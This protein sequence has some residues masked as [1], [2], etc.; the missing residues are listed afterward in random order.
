MDFINVNDA[1]IFLLITFIHF[2]ISLTI[3]L[4]YLFYFSGIKFV[5][6]G[7]VTNDVVPVFPG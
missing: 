1:S 7:Y 4:F 5:P 6:K 3:A 2:T